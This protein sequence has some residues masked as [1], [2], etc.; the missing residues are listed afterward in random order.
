[1]LQPIRLIKLS[2]PAQIKQRKTEKFPMTFDVRTEHPGPLCIHE[3]L[4]RHANDLWVPNHLNE[5]QAAAFVLDHFRR[6]I[7]A[8][9]AVVAVVAKRT[10]TF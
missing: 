2:P 7:E 3:L 5:D 9:L 8:E 4:Q 6:Q 1:L 10:S